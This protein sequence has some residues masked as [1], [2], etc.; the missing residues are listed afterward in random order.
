MSH[1]HL[2][3]YVQEFSGRHNIREHDTVDQTSQLAARMRGK[4]LKYEDLTAS[5]GLK[6]GARSA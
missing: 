3:R 2:D 4:R 1:K 6:S 5:N